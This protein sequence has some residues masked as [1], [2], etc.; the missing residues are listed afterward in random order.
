MN[1]IIM[2]A[3]YEELQLVASASPHGS[4]VKVAEAVGYSLPYIKKLK[5]K[6]NILLDNKTNRT[7][8]HK[9]IFEYR[10]LMDAQSERIKKVQEK[11]PKATV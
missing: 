2:E 7:L 8:M 11:Y 4:D 9:V 1:L 10:K 5:R 6:E 3:L